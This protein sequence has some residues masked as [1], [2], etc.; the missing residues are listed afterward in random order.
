MTA[1]AS[2]RSPQSAYST[3]LVMYRPRKP[4]ACIWLIVN[5]SHAELHLLHAQPHT[6]NNQII[7]HVFNFFSSFLFG[8]SDEKSTE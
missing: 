2:S 8:L 4:P 3:T 1:S 6:K 7:K 5:V